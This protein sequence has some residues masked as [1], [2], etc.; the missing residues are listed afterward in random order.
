MRQVAMVDRNGAVAA[1]TGPRCIAAAGN[2]G[3]KEYSVQANLM[4]SATVWPAMAEAYEHAS[5]DFAER[6]L[7]ALDAAQRAGGDIRG[8]Q[9]AALLI[10]R[11]T[12]TGRPW[13]DRLVELRVED[14]PA[15][16]VEL[17]RLLTL[18]RAYTESGLGDEATAKG[19]WTA[20]EAH[21]TRAAELAPE[22]NELLFWAA[23]GLFMAGKEEQAMPLFARVFAREDR[24]VRLVE[25][26]P[27]SGLLPADPAK[28]AKILSAAPK[29]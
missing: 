24:W 25:R 4:D 28:I 9:S 23:Q 1:W 22:S 12:S 18:Q 10:V 8:M 17:R 15:P 7:A 21:Y 27:A 6:L 14:D 20:A 19:D 2:Q 11:G 29:R 26:L 5:G 13:E 16:L 3:G